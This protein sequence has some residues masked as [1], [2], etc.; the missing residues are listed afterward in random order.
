[1]EL[2]AKTGLSVMLITLVAA[3]FAVSFIRLV[4]FAWCRPGYRTGN[5]IYENPRLL[6]SAERLN[7]WLRYRGIDLSVAL[8]CVLAVYFFAV[9]EADIWHYLFGFLLLPKAFDQAC[10]H[11]QSLLRKQQVREELDTLRQ[12]DRQYELMQALMEQGNKAR[13][14]PQTEDQLGRRSGHLA[15]LGEVVAKGCVQLSNV[16]FTVWL[17]SSIPLFLGARWDGPWP[18]IMV[19]L[20]A[21][22][23]LLRLLS[24][25]VQSRW[26]YIV[27]VFPLTT[28]M[29]FQARKFWHLEEW[30]FLLMSGV[31]TFS[32]IFGMLYLSGNQKDSDE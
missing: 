30:Q 16:V 2:D 11:T 17:F 31:V 25:I 23:F 13:Q 10:L 28:M 19:G 4:T 6:R 12:A 24:M 22:V 8:L 9:S 27:M 18:K 5:I 20:I 1:M 29:L 21:A 3:L 7:V 14:T 15:R 32:L 26:T